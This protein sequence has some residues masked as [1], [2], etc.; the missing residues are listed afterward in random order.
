MGG[1]DQFSWYACIQKGFLDV[2]FLVLKP[3]QSWENQEEVDAIT[4]C[5]KYIGLNQT[6]IIF[7]V[8]QI[9]IPTQIF[10]G[11]KSIVSRAVFL[12][13]GMGRIYFIAFSRSQRPLPLQE[14][15]QC[16]ISVTILLQSPLPLT[17]G[18][19]KCCLDFKAPEII[20][21]PFWIS[22]ET[23]SISRSLIY[24]HLQ[25]PFCLVK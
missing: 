14:C 9:R 11:L 22:S 2:G 8:L 18:R 3:G 13:G 7:I 23:L 19:N 10:I 16:C 4:N 1:S 12:L 5:H 6:F 25:S 17:T 20:W 15:Q 24:S 21:E